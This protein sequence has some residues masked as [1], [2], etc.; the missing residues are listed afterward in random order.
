MDLALSSVSNKQK[1]ENPAGRKKLE[2]A[3]QRT[4]QALEEGRGR[5]R[6]R[7]VRRFSARECEQ[8][9]S[10]CDWQLDSLCSQLLPKGTTARDDTLRLQR[11][12]EIYSGGVK[13]GRALLRFGAQVRKYA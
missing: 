12:H 1:P 11:T 10:H 6:I 8:R 4:E 5:A 9:P 2:Q 13:A 7:R 3:I